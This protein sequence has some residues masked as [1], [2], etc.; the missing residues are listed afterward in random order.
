MK[1]KW[2]IT[3]KCILRARL[4]HYM[5]SVCFK[6]NRFEVCMLEKNRKGYNNASINSY[7]TFNS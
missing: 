6:E 1:Y 2:V 4:K 3:E 7:I 5:I